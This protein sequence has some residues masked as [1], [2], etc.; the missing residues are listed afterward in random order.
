MNHDARFKTLR[1]EITA[2]SASRSVAGAQERP[3]LPATT[4]ELPGASRRTMNC[5]W[6]TWRPARKRPRMRQSSRH[7]R[8]SSNSRNL[9]KVYPTPKGPLTVV[10]G[11][12][13][14]IRQGR[15]RLLIGHSGCGKST[16]LSMAAGLNEISEGRD[17][18]RWP[19]SRQR[20]ARTGGGVPGPQPDAVADRV[21]RT[22][23]WA[24]SGSIPMP[25]AA[26]ARRDR[27]L[28][29]ARVGLGRRDA[30]SAPPS[31]PTA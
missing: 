13:L 6:P 15:V 17:R 20:R 28:L 10:D 25:Q 22:S 5:P 19:R 18:A 30:T 24:S 2:V 7:R 16:V 1:G 31:C 27:R 8:G 29:P 23:R 12:D 4:I 9:S 14:K 26:R 3:Q 11:F 21:R